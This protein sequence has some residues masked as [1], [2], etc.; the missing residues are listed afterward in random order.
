MNMIAYEGSP[1]A[2]AYSA[3]K[4]ALRSMAFK[5]AREIGNDSGVAVFSFVPGIVDTPLMREHFVPKLAAALGVSIEQAKAIAAQNP[6]YDGLMPV[7]HCAT[8][9]VHAIVHGSELHGQVADPFEPLDRVGV[10][11]MPHLDPAAAPAMLDVSGPQSSLYIRQYL[12]DVTTRNRRI[13]CSERLYR[14]LG[15]RF[16][17]QPRGE[18]DIKGKG[19]MPTYFLVGTK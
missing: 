15:E 2:A 18:V 1:L 9:L 12:G 7:D 8:A 16:T 4:M 3:T 6:G 11:R 5:V 13:Q 10:I 17:F 19:L 14:R